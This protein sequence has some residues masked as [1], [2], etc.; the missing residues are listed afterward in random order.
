MYR[1][2]LLL[3]QQHVV[4]ENLSKTSNMTAVTKVRSASFKLVLH[5]QHIFANAFI[6]SHLRVISYNFLFHV[7]VLC[8]QYNTV[9]ANT[10][11]ISVNVCIFVCRYV[12]PSGKCYYNTLLSCKDYFSSSSVVLH[13]FSALCVYSKFGYYPHPL[14][15]L[16]AKFCFFCGLHC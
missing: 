3:S 12:S 5:V 16:C 6:L 4:N 9:L 10:A 14:V 13:N 2:H 15:C 8:I 11:V 7:H 1:T